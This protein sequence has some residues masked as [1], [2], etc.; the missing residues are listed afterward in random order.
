MHEWLDGRQS[1]QFTP[2][3][4]NLHQFHAGLKGIVGV[5]FAVQWQGSGEFSFL[6]LEQPAAVDGFAAGRP[7]RGRWVGM[8]LADAYS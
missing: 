6:K 5:E 1:T 3:Q 8:Q 2:T 4:S 7:L